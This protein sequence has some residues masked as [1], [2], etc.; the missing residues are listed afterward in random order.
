MQ[1]VFVER[2]VKKK[3]S[4]SIILLK[5]LII[6]ASILLAIVLLFVGLFLFTQFVSFAMLLACAAVYGGYMLATSFNLEYETCF[7]N[8]QL[9]VDK[10]INRRRRKRLISIRCKDVETLGKYKAVDHQNKQYKTRIIACDSEESEDVWYLTL[11]H[12]TLGHTLL[13]FNADERLLEG[14]KSYI[15]R[16]LAFQVFG[17]F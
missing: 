11:S 17:R 4:V 12:N 3:L 8:G 2:I 6:T 13:V 14:I 9:D 16:Q 15:P 10:I 1:D 5:I 7:T